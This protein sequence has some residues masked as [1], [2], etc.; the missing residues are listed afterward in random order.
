MVCSNKIHV[1]YGSPTCFRNNLFSNRFVNKPK[2]TLDD[3]H[4]RTALFNKKV[5]DLKD[6]QSQ[7]SSGL[8]RG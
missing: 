3:L 6:V 7:W 8:C 5:Q 2:K 1:I 4:Y